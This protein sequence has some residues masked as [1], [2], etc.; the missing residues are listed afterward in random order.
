MN[1]APRPGRSAQ[2]IATL[3]PASRSRE[4]IASLTAAG[5][6]VAR[7][8][9][10]HASHEDVAEAVR[11]LRGVSS[12]S[13]RAVAIIGD[14]QGPKL[15]IGELAR[16]LRLDVGAALVLTSEPGFQ[17]VDTLSVDDAALHG[18]VV[19]GARLFLKDGTIE[20]EVT[21]RSRSRLETIVRDGGALTSRAGLSVP[22]TDLGLPALTAQDRADLA[23]A[24]TQGIEWLA[25]S[26]V[27][28]ADDLVEAR[29]VLRDAGVPE[30]RLIA[31][32][33]RRAALEDLAAIAEA[34]DALMVARGDLGVEIGVEEVPIWQHRIIAAGK[35]A[36]VPVIVATE[37]LE[38]M[39][40]GERPTR[41]EASDVAHAVWDGAAAL[42][43]SAETAVGRHPVAVVETMDRIIR[44]AEAETTQTEAPGH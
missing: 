42:M 34:S 33:E 26:F 25:L 2:I 18:A 20:L 6:D 11:H 24:L 3:G 7:L 41:A 32:I 35:R 30:V 14:L 9:F 5:M 39:R 8:N 17:G 28:H 16:E 29:A 36:G 40:T 23:F 12:S 43:L 44:R 19:P 37:M 38:S 13:G 27:R 1:D 15:R 10:S 21:A 31:K 4:V 22:R